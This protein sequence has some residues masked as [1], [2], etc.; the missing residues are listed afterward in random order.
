M[1]LKPNE[2]QEELWQ[3]QLQF[4]HMGP[5][6]DS[7]SLLANRLYVFLDYVGAL[8]TS[9]SAPILDPQFDNILSAGQRKLGL[10]LR[11]MLDNLDDAARA[12]TEYTTL[13]TQVMRFFFFFLVALIRTPP[14]R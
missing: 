9:S 11:N 3:G 4:A 6:E 5:D 2:L 1:L 10:A 14:A 7:F 13:H 8:T 12:T